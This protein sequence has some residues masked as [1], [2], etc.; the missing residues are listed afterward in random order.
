MSQWS[1]QH[2][3]SFCLGTQCNKND[4]AYKDQEGCFLKALSHAHTQVVLF[5]KMGQMNP[6]FEHLSGDIYEHQCLLLWI[7]FYN[8]G[9]LYHIACHQKKYAVLLKE[10]GQYKSHMKNIIESLSKEKNTMGE[11]QFTCLLE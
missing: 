5:L 11:K 1:L 10:I 6:H 2:R 9:N 7:I 3:C 8:V 4:Q